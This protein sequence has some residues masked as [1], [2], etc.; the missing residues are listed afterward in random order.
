M[1]NCERAQM[2][3]PW[4]GG[5]LQGRGSSAEVG[6]QIAEGFLRTAALVGLLSLA[7][8]RSVTGAETVWPAQAWEM[9]TPEPQGVDSGSLARLVDNVGG[10]KQDSL[11][12]IRHGRIVLDVYWPPYRAGIRHDLRSVTKSVTGTLV[13]IALQ[14]GVL[15][16]T[17]RPVVDFFADKTI[18]NFDAAKRAITLQNL[19]DMASGLAWQEQAYTPDEPLLQMYA[20]ADRTAFVLNRKMADPPGSRFTYNSGNPYVLSAVLT[21]LTGISAAA[22]AERELF[23]PLGITGA[24]WDEPDA[25]GV[26]DGEAGLYLTPHDMARLGYLYLQGGA[27]N[28]KR[29][30]P[31][32]WVARARAGAIEATFGF[33]Y[34]DLWW[35]LPEKDAFLASGRHSQRIVVLPKLDIVAVMTG[36][37]RDDE[38]YSHGRLIDEIASA[39]KSDQSLPADV[40]GSSVLAASLRH[41]AAE[42]ATPI[43]ATPD[44]AK[45]VSGK[46]YRFADNALR[47]RSL[48]LTLVGAAPSWEVIEVPAQADAPAPR[49]AGPIGLDGRFRVGPETRHGVNATKGYWLNDRTFAVER[50][51]LGHGETQLW[52][53]RFDGTKLDFHFADSDGTQAEL[54]GETS[55]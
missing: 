53:L 2:T 32:S 29:L 14:Q 26:T 15:D 49:F 46:L 31:A 35:S 13:A 6:K 11:L 18:E 10:Y 43:G 41:A 42:P 5:V 40:V 37:L 7:A 39:V 54:S 9:S 3:R 48:T 24:R 19:L 4:R 16:R 30:I 34:A 28:G 21:K 25:Q 1:R 52:T 47:V 45:A 22:F 33:H 38:T 20:S 12:I 51:V 8:A 23:A 17:D 50:R 36:I 44:L 27:W 55:D